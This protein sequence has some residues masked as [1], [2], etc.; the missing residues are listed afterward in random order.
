MINRF[1]KKHSKSLYIFFLFL[2][3]NIFF[4]STVNSEAKAF[5][6]K[7]IE[8]TRPFEIN[9]NKNEVIDEGFNKAFF[10]L[11]S[12]I[13]KSSDR[14]KISQIK[15][16]EIKGM[17]ETFSIKEEK[18]INDTYY[19]NLGVSFN[20][21]RIFNYLEKKKYFSFDPKRKNI[22]IDTNIN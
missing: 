12:I 3:L 6:V 7:D 16:N 5:D 19:V 4:F 20:K 10:E 15:L 13:T 22:S 21:K 14:K 17:V 9:F 1:I 11:I 2:S 18:F 8:I